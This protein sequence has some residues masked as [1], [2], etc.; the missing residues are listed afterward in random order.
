MS[1]R[2]GCGQIGFAFFSLVLIVAALAAGSC[3]P[4]KPIVV[5]GLISETGA[6][7]SYGTAIRKGMDLA[8]EE[9]NA[10]GGFPNGRRLEVQYRDDGSSPEKAKALARELI[11]KTKVNS[12]LGAV[13][14][15]VAIDV[16][17]IIREKE[18]VLLSPSASSPQLTTSGAG[19]FFRNYPSDL[20]EGQ[21]MGVLAIKLDLEK[22]A[23]LAYQDPFGQTIAEIFTNQLEIEKNRKVTLRENFRSPLSIE[24]AKD[25]AKKVVL[26]GAQGVYLAGY[27]DDVATLLQELQTAGFKGV[28]MAPSAVTANVVQLAGV[29]ADR[30]V[31]PQLAQDFDPENPEISKF[32]AA[33][34]KKYN[35]AP[36]PFAAY[37]YDAM[38]VLAEAVRRTK[39]ATAGEVRAQLV[40]IDHKG[41]TGEI[42]FDD[43]GDVRREPH[44]HVVVGSEVIHFE[45]IDESIRALLLP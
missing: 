26:S 1:R 42:R 32:V 44:L 14:S 41:V 15:A 43:R 30:L 10:Q 22:V 37:G 16:L 18:V 21:A 3:A 6:A 19:W 45:G 4:P 31:F 9:E 27:I 38:K 29:A 34:R 8:L 35:R 39:L 5:G 7:A 20:A 33:F 28:K 40:N 36:E 12:M 25:L 23:V 11:E 17:P 24:T 13:S 2:P